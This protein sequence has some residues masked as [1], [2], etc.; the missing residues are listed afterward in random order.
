MDTVKAR[1][2]GASAAS[3]GVPAGAGV[4]SAGGWFGMQARQFIQGFTNK[5]LDK[6]LIILCIIAVE[7]LHVMS[8]QAL[9]VITASKADP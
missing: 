6:V 8:V 5:T 9:Q 2:A 7:I 1:P 4:R 3:V